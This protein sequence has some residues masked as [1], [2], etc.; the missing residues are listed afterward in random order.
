MQR[1][2]VLDLLLLEADG[3][4]STADA[5]R[6]GEAL[7]KDPT[8]RAERTKML[9]AWGELRELGRS[10]ALKPDFGENRLAALRAPRREGVLIGGQVRA[11]AAALLLTSLLR[12]AFDPRSSIVVELGESG[13]VNSAGAKGV[14]PSGSPITTDHGAPMKVAAIDGLRCAMREGSIALNADGVVRIEPGPADID[15][16]IGERSA[17]IDLGDVVLYGANAV[18]HVAGEPFVARQFD[19]I[20]G[21]VRVGGFAGR[22]ISHRDGALAIGSD[23][24]LIAVAPKSGDATGSDPSSGASRHETAP[25]PIENPDKPS[26][27]ADPAVAAVRDLAS[28][29]VFGL[30]TA[31]SDGTPLP[32]ATVRLTRDLLPNDNLGSLLP[33]DPEQRLAALRD[34][35]VARSVLGA[36]ITIQT[37]VDGRYDLPKVAPGIWRVDVL[38]PAKPARCDLAGQFVQ[39]PSGGE[40]PLDLALADAATVN[41]KLTDHSGHAVSGALVDDGSRSVITDHN[42]KFVLR[43]VPTTG[44][45]VFIQAE[46]FEDV[47]AT[48]QGRD[49]N[50]ISLDIATTIR[51][52]IRAASGETLVGRIEAGFELDGIWRVE[53]ANVDRSGEF[54]LRTV[55]LDVP[56]RLVA[57]S[58]GHLI[59][60]T[61]IDA[62]AD[63]S[64]PFDFALNASNTV[65]VFPFDLGYGRPIDTATV[66]ATAPDELVAGVELVES[67]TLDGL[68]SSATNHAITWAPG[69]RYTAFD[70][71][72]NVGV[73]YVDMQPAHERHVHV[74]DDLGN[75]LADALVVWSARPSDSTRFLSVVPAVRAADGYELPDYGLDGSGLIAQITVVALGQTVIVVDDPTRD[76]TVVTVSSDN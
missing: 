49:T 6:L 75:D 50:R 40:L 7:S 62:G 69:L 34:L 53:R 13:A 68:D 18:L 29:H 19:V 52:T 47:D 26:G 60:A 54:A 59:G 9:A 65:T 70:V 37:D 17:R 32:G 67:I 74:V 15:I 11:A 46:G 23:G 43:N 27:N 45:R 38:S 30:V 73:V 44:V 64:A 72:P 42:G 66:L 16:E 36:P 76:D 33:N 3:G 2:E 39:V 14:V 63:R 58:G 8:L 71:A 25:E 1:E 56:V 5:A 22:T 31:S 24:G 55:P 61:F 48:L 57:S 41:G 28:A 35:D 21:S 12:G 51:G 4:L 10:I 20:S